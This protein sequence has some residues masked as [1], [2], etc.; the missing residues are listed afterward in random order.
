MT[1]TT[2]QRHGDTMAVVT[3]EL[4]PAIIAWEGVLDAVHV[5][6]DEHYHESP[7]DS[8]DGYDHR[9]INLHGLEK[10]GFSAFIQNGRWMGV[11][12]AR[13]QNLYDW[14]RRRGASKG[15]AD[16]LVRWSMR[17]RTEQIVEW[18]RDGWKWWQVTGELHGCYAAVG[19]VDDYD[20]AE[21]CRSEIAHE[22][23]CELEKLGY[24]VSG[25]P[26]LKQ[27]NRN[28]R[29]E[30]YRSNINLFNAN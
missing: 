2:H 16:Q 12:I 27:D 3:V 24:E 1:Q 22:L 23:A 13:D 19:G 26:D 29:R 11:E 4:R 8:C 30:H 17:K 6:I 14:Y 9:L 20:Y 15:V 25:R 21:E 28:H 5:D 18:Y 7:W 10:D